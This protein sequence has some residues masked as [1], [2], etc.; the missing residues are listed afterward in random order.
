MVDYILMI[1]TAY[2]INYIFLKYGVFS[3]NSL[4][5]IFFVTSNDNEGDILYGKCNYRVHGSGD[6]SAK[7]WSLTCDRI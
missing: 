1:I 4:D 3:H 6:I 7:F 2:I 5:E